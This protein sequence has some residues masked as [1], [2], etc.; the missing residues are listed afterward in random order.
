LPTSSS[1]SDS[2]TSSSCAASGNRLAHLRSALP[3]GA[4]RLREFVGDF[5]FFLNANLFQRHVVFDRAAAET[6]VLRVV[7]VRVLE[8]RRL[9]CLPA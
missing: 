9:A 8:R 7:A 1:T 2:G 5:R 3:S 4:D 6:L